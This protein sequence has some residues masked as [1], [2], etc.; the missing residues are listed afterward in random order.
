VKGLPLDVARELLGEGLLTTEGAVHRRQRKATQ[1]AFRPER[2]QS[3]GDAA[4]EETLAWCAR[5]EEGGVLD[6]AREMSD[7]AVAIAARTMLGRRI[8]PDQAAGVSKALDDALVPYTPATLPYARLKLHLP[9]P[10]SFRFRR[11]RSHLQQFVAHAIREHRKHPERYDDLLTILLRSHD[12]DGEDRVMADRRV[13]DEAVTIL[14]A[15]FETTS[16][17]IAWSWYLLSEHPDEE[18]RLHAETHAV[19]SGRPPA[20]S[21]ARLLRHTRNVFAES[22]RIYPPAYAVVRETIRDMDLGEYVVPA[23]TLLLMCPY[24]V[25]RDERFFPDPLRFDPDRWTAE[26]KASLPPFAYFPFGGGSRRCIGEA[27]AWDE[28]TL[29]LATI[30]Q[31]WR[32]R[33]LPGHPVEPQLFIHMQPRYGLPMTAYRR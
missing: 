17:A 5:W 3:Y 18:E 27:V 23:R 31:R 16:R 19:L 24:V 33:L 7:L 29:V 11:A 22:M 4:V 15:S 26:R 32:L 21:D 28:G 25:Q 9:L 2:I 6:V 13:I 14:V 20:A 12:A 8:G 10:S 1:P 30:A